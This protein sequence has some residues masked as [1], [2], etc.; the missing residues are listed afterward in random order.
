MTHWPIQRTA[1]P[2]LACVWLP[3]EKEWRSYA[4]SEAIENVSMH[5]C[6]TLARIKTE[7]PSFIT[8]KME[9][10]TR[11]RRGGDDSNRIHDTES[12]LPSR[13]D[14]GLGTHPGWVGGFGGGAIIH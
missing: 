12:G 9:K 2:A 4:Q 3:D 10:K 14:S 8:K 13:N 11:R 7:M 5:V 6:I 1:S